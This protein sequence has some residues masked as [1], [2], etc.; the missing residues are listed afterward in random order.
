MTYLVNDPADFAADALRGYVAAHPRHVAM[1]HGGVV[2]STETPK[3]QP[4]LV[5]GGGSGHYPAFAGW[6]GPGMGHG[7][8]CGNIFS[9]PSASQV[10]S[11]ARS[12]ENGGGVILGFGNYAGDVLHFGQAAEKLRAEGVDVRIIR[13]S[14]DVAS[15]AAGDHR[16]RRGIA[17]DLVVFKIAGAAIEA[18]ADLDEAERLAWK[19]NDA[20]RSF[21]VA[22]KGCTLPGAAGALFHV[23]VGEM[24]I[25]LGIH[26]EPG[27][28]E[29]PMG[30]AVEIADLLLDGVLAEEP[31]H[32]G[33]GY[34]GRV[35]VLLNGLGT[36]K[37][38][39]L[40]V[41]YGRVAE[42][43]AARGLTVVAPEVGE[44]VT[45]LD[46]AGLSL[47]L[48]F[49]DDELEKYWL[50]PADT[51]A[52][53]REAP[54]LA[55]RPERTGV[56]VPGEEPIPESTAESRELAERIAEA[57]E[58]I[59]SAAAEN[60]EYFGRLDAVAG[61]GDHGQGMAYGSRGAAT[62]GSAAAERGA[63][64]R[65][66]LI[67]AGEAWAEEAGGTSGALW[68]AA[69]TAAGGVFDDTRG[70]EPAEVV[71][72]IVEGI[73]AIVRIGGAVPGDKTMVDS[74]LP[75]RDVLVAEFGRSSDLAGATKKA[76]AAAREAAESTAQMTARLGRA[77]VLG[78]KSLGTPDPGAVSF[79]LLMDALGDFFR[80]GTVASKALP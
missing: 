42:R 6:I 73:E 33:D 25:G 13:V 1:A 26:G 79:S 37:Y 71:Q 32:T 55:A 51:P 72:A 50:A 27:I 68:G 47:T 10:Y 35:A 36:V 45:S 74:A 53:R 65:T 43:L 4:A 54:D 38:E 19:T 59:Q 67:H 39:E 9:S 63:G 34:R 46:M 48:L 64:A 22:F 29:V 70:T 3:G 28:R 75:F 7:A 16:D 15:A 31:E 20:T 49:L 41:V 8:P 23:P 78:E 77:R 52:F 30:T 57:L 60:E 5:I 61:D 17:G 2:R 80:S 66:V 58:L 24:G 62:S 56:H 21:G 18:G 40:F 69:L 76:A 12:A 14:D 11:V 44:H